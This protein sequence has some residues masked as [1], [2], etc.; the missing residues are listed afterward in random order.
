M[1]RGYGKS[2]TKL[3]IFIGYCGGDGERN[4]EGGWCLL[5]GKVLFLFLG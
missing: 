5:I 3:V 1:C 2:I 4:G